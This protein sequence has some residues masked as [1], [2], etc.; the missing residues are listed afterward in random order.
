MQKDSL[1]AH[2]QSD[3]FRDLLLFFAEADFVHDRVDAD[4]IRLF[5]RRL[6]HGRKERIRILLCASLVGD[7]SV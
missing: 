3:G 5:R 4:L 1:F 7:H 6:F 2:A